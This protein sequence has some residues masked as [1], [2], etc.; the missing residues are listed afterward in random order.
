MKTYQRTALDGTKGPLIRLP[1]V[2][3]T[4]EEYEMLKREE[5]RRRQEVGGCC[6]QEL[7]EPQPFAQP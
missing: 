1:E 7:S 3:M 4:K 6:G 2:Q 5:R